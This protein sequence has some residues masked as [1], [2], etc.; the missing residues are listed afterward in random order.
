M[1]LGQ[2]LT[3]A[4]NIL[5]RGTSEY[6]EPSTLG[7]HLLS[8][9]LKPGGE[10][11]ATNTD[12]YLGAYSTM[13]WLRAV[14]SRIGHD[15]GAADWNLYVARRN[16]RA[17]RS[18]SIQY[19]SAPDRRKMMAKAI[20]DEQLE[21]VERHPLL[22]V[23]D[24]PNAYHSGPEVRQLTQIHEELTGE[25][26]WLIERNKLGLPDS[27]WPL[28][29]SW[30]KRTPTPSKPSYEIQFQGVNMEVP[31]TEV[32]WFCDR[33]PAN[34]YGRGTGIA[35]A[36]ADELEAD[37]YAAKT[38]K[39]IFFNNAQP[40]LIISPKGDGEMRDEDV[41]RIENDWNRRNRGFF[42]WFKTH[43][44]RLGVDVKPLAIDLRA[45]E[46]IKLRKYEREVVMQVFGVSPEIL[47]VVMPGSSRASTTQQR[48][49]YGEKVLVPRLE[50]MRAVLQER[51]VPMYD[52]RLII[53]YTS[54]STED[55][56]LQLEA[57]QAAP[58][59]LMVDEWRRK[60]GL[61]PLP[62]GKGQV[63][64]VPTT[65]APA[66]SLADFEPMSALSIEAS[67]NGNES[68][69]V[70]DD[71][72]CEVAHQMLATP[73]KKLLI[74]IAKQDDDEPPLTT[75]GDRLNPSF[76]RAQEASWAELADAADVGAIERG[77]TANDEEEVL[78]GTGGLDA[79]SG[80][81]AAP[82]LQLGADYFMRGASHALD[83]LPP[84]PERAPLGIDLSSVN[85]LA[86][87]WAEAQAAQLVANVSG[88]VKD[89]IRA[90]IAMGND[91]G[92]APAVLARR[93]VDDRVFGLLPRQVTAIGRFRQSLIDSG[94]TG[95]ALERRVSRYTKAQL[96]RRA[97]TIAHHET[98]SALNNGQQGLWQEANRRDLLP[99]GTKRRW[100]ATLDEFLESICEALHGTEVGMDEPF[101]GG[102]MVPPE[103]HVGCRCSMALAIPKV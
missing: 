31:V 46:M 52:D 36:L 15:V 101:P 73:K 71:I 28:V 74:G 67:G 58:H 30:V 24:S 68:K 29:P 88:Q 16:G 98:L 11:P 13:P 33:D 2:R 34:P 35:R 63:H 55:E 70:K 85:P 100:L 103:A 66:E 27:F 93:F 8:G 22:D 10:P 102:I 57:S 12:D 50:L 43:F 37:E 89:T 92:I 48:L 79:V 14:A 9:V 99:A 6:P 90:W 5:V 72:A 86:T 44:F 7:G 25:G 97:K 75:M 76:V 60:Q 77:I 94:L 41:R 21:L 53:D 32:V 51:I 62:D 69:A 82:L 56:E 49:M 20:R 61:E 59:T 96:R 23:L 18:K 54:P 91:Q 17:V 26:F 78:R 42:R 64:M 84:I 81:L 39:S 47:G 40:S 45:L 1:T 83:N 80:A 95:D 87:A 65:L 4:A 19:A 38:A 3:Q